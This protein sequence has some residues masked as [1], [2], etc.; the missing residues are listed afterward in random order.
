[1]KTQPH[2]LPLCE[3]MDHEEMC[4]VTYS[5]DAQIT[6]AHWPCTMRQHNG[7]RGDRTPGNYPFRIGAIL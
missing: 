4:D 6:E 1:M 2:T 3:Q 7:D 5:E